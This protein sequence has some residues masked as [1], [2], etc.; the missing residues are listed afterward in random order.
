MKDLLG[1]EMSKGDFVVSIDVWSGTCSAGLAII[2][3]FT[4]KKVRTFSKYR[5]KD[6]V[7]GNRNINPG[8]DVPTRLVVVGEE[9]A[10]NVLG[11]DFEA[12]NEFRQTLI[13][14]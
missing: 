12:I 9:T 3:D 2:A 7:N 4:P 11:D 10:R 14:G 1:Q 5:L 13:D 6:F 8:L